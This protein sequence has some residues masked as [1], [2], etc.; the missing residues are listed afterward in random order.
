MQKFLKYSFYTVCLVTFLYFFGDFRIN[1]VNVRD[2]IRSYVT[3]Q[4]IQMI[5]SRLV[6]LYSAVEGAINHTPAGAERPMTA[7]SQG[8]GAA[9]HV[10]TP[11]AVRSANETPTESQKQAVEDITPSDKKR[12]TDLLKKHMQ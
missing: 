4:N 3:W 2:T 8:N 6:H 10:V 1:D 7:E 12:M 5:R 11:Q 9:W